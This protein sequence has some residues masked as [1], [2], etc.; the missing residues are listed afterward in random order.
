MYVYDVSY[1]GF[2]IFNDRLQVAVSESRLY[3]ASHGG[4]SRTPFIIGLEVEVSCVLV[5]IQPAPWSKN[6]T[7][8]TSTSEQMISS[9]PG[10]EILFPMGCVKLGN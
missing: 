3:F 4:G 8:E 5:M 7:H 9:V 2:F 6:K 1:V 10:P